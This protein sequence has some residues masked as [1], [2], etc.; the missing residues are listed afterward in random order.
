MVR[1]SLKRTFIALPL[2]LANWAWPVSV[3]FLPLLTG[4]LPPFFLF[5]SLFLFQR[6]E[7]KS[8]GL[9]KSLLANS[10]LRSVFPEFSYFSINIIKFIIRVRKKMRFSLKFPSSFSLTV[11]SVSP[12]SYWNQYR[13]RCSC[14]IFIFL[15]FRPMSDSLRHNHFVCAIFPLFSIRHHPFFFAHKCRKISRVR[16]TSTGEVLSEASIWGSSTL[17]WSRLSYSFWLNI[18]KRKLADYSIGPIVPTFLNS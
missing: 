11:T 3:F 1:Y 2:Q 7:K 6:E 12:V 17:W 16:I 5:L 15:H 8:V 9:P 13:H 4:F 18:D 10:Q 14:I